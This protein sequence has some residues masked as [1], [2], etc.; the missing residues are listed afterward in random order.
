MYKNQDVRLVNE[1]GGGGVRK[2]H[3]ETHRPEGQE[4]KTGGFR[5]AD[6]RRR[7]DETVECRIGRPNYRTETGET[8]R[9]NRRELSMPVA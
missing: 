9:I 8:I 1:A 6:E 7:N 5:M 3:I 2:V 4:T